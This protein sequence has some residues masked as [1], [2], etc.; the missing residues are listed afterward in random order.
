MMPAQTAEA[1]A[2]AEI[3]CE[4]F[5]QQKQNSLK[6]APDAEFHDITDNSLTER[7]RLIQ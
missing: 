2:L 6:P 7:I 5:V 4:I 3:L 1:T